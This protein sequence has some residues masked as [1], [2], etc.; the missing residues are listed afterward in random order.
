MNNPYIGHESQLYGIEQTRLVGGKGDGMRLLQVRNAGG[1]AFTVAADR[2]ADVYRLQFQGINMGFF[3][4]NGYVAPAYYQEQGKGFLKSFT[5]GFFTTCGLNNVGAPCTVDGV[6]YPLHGTIGNSPA[7]HI[8][9]TETPETM[10]IHA[11]IRDSA[12]FGRKLVL[13][14]TLTCGKYENRLIITDTVENRGDI[15]EPI[16]L[17][18]HMNMGYPLLTENAQLSN[19][20]VYRMVGTERVDGDA[21]KQPEPPQPGKPEICYRHYYN[22]EERAEATIRNPEI[23]KGLRISFDPKDFPCMVQW[24]K[25]SYRDY[26]LGLE[27]RSTRYGGRAGTKAREEDTA[28]APG[29]RRTYRVTVD[30]F[31]F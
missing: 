26:A 13:H 15:P 21:W 6:S 1:L 16:F 20:S 2:C 25:F 14:R 28:L 22:G 3:A 17:M 29:A 7:E 9:W 27:P 12:I 18:Y 31:A 23:R 4:P 19:N 11:V 10:E 5:A 24:N 30:F 8:W